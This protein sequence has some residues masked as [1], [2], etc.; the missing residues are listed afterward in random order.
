MATCQHVMH[1]YNYYTNCH[2]LLSCASLMIYSVI[3]TAHSCAQ[4]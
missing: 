4:P 1:G 2:F 3:I